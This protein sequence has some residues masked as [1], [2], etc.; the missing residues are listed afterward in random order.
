MIALSG[1]IIW[2]LC[3]VPRDNLF[4]LSEERPPHKV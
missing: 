3:M 1:F 2:A 4:D